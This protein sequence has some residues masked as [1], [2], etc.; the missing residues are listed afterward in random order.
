M[1]AR[2]GNAN[3]MKDMS[4]KIPATPVGESVTRGDADIGCQQISEL[5]VSIRQSPA[6][7]LRCA[8]Y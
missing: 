4:G 2:L 7:K 5:R 8:D 1:F 3:E 6:A